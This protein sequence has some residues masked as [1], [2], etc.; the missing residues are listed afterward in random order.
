MSTLRLGPLLLVASCIFITDAD[1]LAR[2]GGSSGDTGFALGDDDDIFGDDDDDDDEGVAVP[3]EWRAVSVGGYISCAIAKPYDLRCWGQYD[4]PEAWFP[5]VPDDLDFVD[6]SV[7]LEIGC[8]W[9]ADGNVRCF[10]AA[11]GDTYDPER[12]VMEDPGIQVD[13]GVQCGSQECCALSGGDLVC[14]NDAI[15]D[16]SDFVGLTTTTGL[17]QVEGWGGWCTL[18]GAGAVECFRTFSTGGQEPAGDGYDE[19]LYGTNGWGC[20]VEGEDISCFNSERSGTLT[21]ISA[22]DRSE[23]TELH[24]IGDSNVVSVCGLRG[25]N[26]ECF[27]PAQQSG[28]DTQAPEGPWTQLT[29]FVSEGCVLDVDGKAACWGEGAQLPHNAAR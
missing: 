26:V 6:V 12:Q 20:V 4:D 11:G 22:P 15:M 3:G 28:Y 23:L 27:H 1:R 10:G 14:W 16:P 21:E 17:T 19:L 2:P 9:D 29:L 7:G 25:G 8:A 18:D 24:V 13:D 5:P